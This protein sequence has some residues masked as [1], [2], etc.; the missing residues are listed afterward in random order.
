[1]NTST[2][3]LAVALPSF[4][5]IPSPRRALLTIQHVGI[6]NILD[7]TMQHRA[8]A[9]ISRRGRA[10]TTQPDEP[11]LRPEEY[12]PET[13]R[14]L[15]RLVRLAAAVYH[16]DGDGGLARV[17][18]LIRRCVLWRRQDGRLRDRVRLAREV[19]DVDLHA[20]VRELRDGRPEGD[21]SAAG[22]AGG[23]SAAQDILTQQK[24]RADSPMDAD[25]MRA[26]AK[27]PRLDV[28]E[29]DGEKA[30]ALSHVKKEDNEGGV[31]ET[32]GEC[33]Q[34]VKPEVEQQGSDEDDNDNPQDGEQGA[35]KSKRRGRKRGR[36]GRQ[37]REQA[38]K[39]EKRIE[40]ASHAADMLRAYTRHDT[41]AL[42]EDFKSHRESDWYIHLLEAKVC[43]LESTKEILCFSEAD[44]E[45]EAAKFAA[46]LIASAALGEA[47]RRLEG[48]SRM[49]FLEHHLLD[50]QDDRTH[51][52]HKC[53][54]LEMGVRKLFEHM[55]ERG[56]DMGRD[57]EE[58]VEAALA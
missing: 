33:E 15:E 56:V 36:A 35:Q 29:Q 30:G 19:L 26:E 12:R 13:L 23:G 48:K 25:E 57:L 18:A 21:G 46:H 41:A 52:E 45:P 55:K 8:R 2:A 9:S 11:V 44:R 24:R 7:A 34:V 47:T 49:E 39:K 6:D 50:M 17:R 10:R 27:K 22:G 32:M 4:S 14:Q 38:L 53:V 20:A 43:R 40:E 51:M 16:D 5:D 42:I 1:M 37:R 54:V 58:R 31:K 28:P 3:S